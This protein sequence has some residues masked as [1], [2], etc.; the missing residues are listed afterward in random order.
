MGL[1]KLDVKPRPFFPVAIKKL[2][3]DRS[4]EDLQISTH[5]ILHHHNIIE[6]LFYYVCVHPQLKKMV[7]TLILERMP[8]TVAHQQNLLVAKGR[9][10]HDIYVRVLF[11]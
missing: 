6:L 11:L 8:T 7:W 4:R 9:K 1:K 5:R 2:W 3:P 10:M